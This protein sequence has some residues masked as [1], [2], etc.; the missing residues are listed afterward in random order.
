MK[1]LHREWAGSYQEAIQLVLLRSG[2]KITIEWTLPRIASEV[3]T[4]SG[5][6]MKSLTAQTSFESS[7]KRLDH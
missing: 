5:N 1:A 7:R 2:I 4:E 3:D 6:Q